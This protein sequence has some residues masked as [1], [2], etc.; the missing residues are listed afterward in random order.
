MDGNG[1]RALLARIERTHW[2]LA[3]AVRDGRQPERDPDADLL[4][5]VGEGFRLYDGGREKRLVGD[6]WFPEIFERRDAAA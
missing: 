2:S 5:E 6:A 4:L 3:G 1:A